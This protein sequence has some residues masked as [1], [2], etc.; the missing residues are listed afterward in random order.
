MKSLLLCLTCILSEKPIQSSPELLQWLPVPFKA[1]R[2]YVLFSTKLEGI[3]K[4]DII[5]YRA[6]AQVTNDTGANVLVAS[7]TCFASGQKFEDCFEYVN[8]GAGENSTP[9]EHHHI[10]SETFLRQANDNYPE[11]FINTIV[12]A[13]SRASNGS[14]KLR[15]DQGYG[16]VTGSIRSPN[17]LQ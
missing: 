5:D 12:W 11:L 13:A 7:R 10:I 1:T 16:T 4:G 9:A 8:Q 17:K 6:R 15:V 3:R 2:G 14:M